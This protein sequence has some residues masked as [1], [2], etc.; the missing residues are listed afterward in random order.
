MKLPLS[1]RILGWF[2]INLLIVVIAF[3]IFFQSQLHLGLDSFFA[4]QARDRITSL[5]RLINDELRVAP[6]Q[7]WNAILARFESA[8]RIQFILVDGARKQIA[9][10][11]TEIP[12]EV[13][14][15]LPGP[16]NR[17][18]GPPEM[19]HPF[20][21]DPGPPGND[22]PHPGP[23][24]RLGPGPE[25]IRAGNPTRYWMVTKLPPLPDVR[26]LP[27]FLVVVT[28]SLTAGGLIFDVRPW[29]FAAAGVIVLSVLFWLP[30][31]RG[32]TRDISKMTAA[33]GQ[34]AAGNFS[35]RSPEER[36]DE[37]GA[38]GQSINRMSDRL[39]GFIQGQKRFLG[40]TAHEL[41]SPLARMEMGL[42]ILEQ[43]VAEKDRAYLADVH[44][45]VRH[46]SD[47]VNELLSFSKASLGLSPKQFQTIS[48]AEL[49]DKTLKREATDNI[50]RFIPE[51]LQVRGNFDI[52]QR[53]LGNVVRNSLRHAG[54]AGPLRI[55]AF[56]LGPEVTITIADNGPGIPEEA[57]SQIFDPFFRPDASRDRATG[58]T[59]LGLAITKSCVEACGGHVSCRNR[60]PNG[61]E[62]LIVLPTAD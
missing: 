54:H 34:I 15:R 8:Y 31:V 60:Q 4:G 39:A 22:R 51:G 53:A 49:V 58:G 1:L 25:I 19:E 46:M 27:I 33:T 59:G 6:A 56:Q 32:M 36:G 7:N 57:L 16:R 18:P 29:L 12:P 37:L 43:Q 28:D 21:G 11:S 3:V 23:P 35:A 42:G 2:F 38:L 13:F 55:S 9:G 62:M 14:Q 10:R 47:L 40:D 61:L 44:E 41:V 45:E 17:P 50:T 30:L 20:D 26:P 24:P 52:L 5:T 48:V